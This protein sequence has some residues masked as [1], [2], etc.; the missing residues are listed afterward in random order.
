MRAVEN[1][2]ICR[3]FGITIFDMKAN[4]PKG[5]APSTRGR[6]PIGQEAMVV[7]PIRMEPAQREK[8]QRLGGAEWVR[9]KIDK[10]RDPE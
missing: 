4:P 3:Q 8:L 7:V 6:K 9:S 10:A 1:G 5:G 2:C